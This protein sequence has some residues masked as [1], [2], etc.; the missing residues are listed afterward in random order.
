MGL[1]SRQRV[2]GVCIELSH[3][4]EA[5]ISNFQKNP[6]RDGPRHKHRNT[7]RFRPRMQQQSGFVR[8]SFWFYSNMLSA[9][10]SY[11]HTIGLQVCSTS[12]VDQQDDVFVAHVT[13]ASL[14][15]CRC[16]L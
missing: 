1:Y 15:G 3:E 9:N 16:V 6:R 5:K 14:T 11:F 13:L 8:V 10:Y 7:P 2:V 4:D 12:L